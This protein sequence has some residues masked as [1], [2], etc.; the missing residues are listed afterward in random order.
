MLL[1]SW[2]FLSS[3]SAP[4]GFLSNR[5]EWPKA[6]T[7]AFADTQWPKWAPSPDD[8]W[9]ATEDYGTVH[10]EAQDLFI[11]ATSDKTGRT[12]IYFEWI[13]ETMTERK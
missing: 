3:L 2:L 7:E 10:M 9:Y 1:S 6:L 8:R 5:A 13:F 11:L 4:R 12:R